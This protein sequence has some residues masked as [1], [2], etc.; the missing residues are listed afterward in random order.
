MDFSFSDDQQMLR[1]SVRRMLDTHA[2]R[3]DGVR[4]DDPWQ[5]YVDMGLTGL[6][7]SEGDGGF[8]G[9]PVDAMIV[10]QETGRA[11]ATAPYLAQVVL[12]GALLEPV[13]PGKR[14]PDLIR[15]IIGGRA[16]VAPALYEPGGRFD[17]LHVATQA[18]PTADGYRLTGSKAVVPGGDTATHLIVSARVSGK[19]TDN[20][21]ISLFVCEAG[22]A[23]LERR[24]YSTIDGTGACELDLA[25]AE[26]PAR[27]CIGKPGAAASI[28]Q[29]AIDCAVA[30]RCG[31]AIG[32][33]EA[34]IDLTRDYLLTRR[35]F[36]QPLAN[37]QVLRHKFADMICAF[38]Q[39]VSM[40]YLAASAV[41]APDDSQRKKDVSAAA[42]LI[43]QSARLIAHESVQMHGGIGMTQEFALGRYLKR[44]TAIG[45][46]FGDEDHHLR[47][48]GEAA[49]AIA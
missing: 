26:V 19:V 10:M 30:A 42:W 29:A 46:A 37:F 45:I 34:V 18:E 6:P 8:G 39:A 21:G 41:S 40:S 27:A 16:R 31:E 47:R 13:S 35:Q 44:L 32:A 14:P 15:A 5:D 4:I 24:S 28:I 22:A 11:L 12:A 17:P 3:G 36:G 33:M 9:G 20:D 7:F 25:R 49:Y 2:A 38:E 48:H 1:A 43:G 23:G